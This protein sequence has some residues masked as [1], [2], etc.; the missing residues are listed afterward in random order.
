MLLGVVM[1]I[2]SVV[3]RLL[4]RNWIT[5]VTPDKE[6]WPHHTPV[7]V[8]YLVSNSP[9]MY[10][11]GGGEEDAETFIFWLHIFFSIFWDLYFCIAGL[12]VVVVSGILFV[13]FV[14][15]C[16]WMDVYVFFQNAFNK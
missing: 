11:Y 12:A 4:P 9:K 10:V 6:I 15:L 7:D 16:N 8:D 5:A 1:P 3:G 2:A 13:L 14:Y